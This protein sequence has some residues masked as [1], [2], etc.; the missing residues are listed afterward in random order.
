MDEGKIDG[1]EDWG[2]YSSYPTPEHPPIYVPDDLTA[3][4]LM[5]YQLKAHLAFY[6]RPKMAVHHF[7][8]VRTLKLE[9]ARMG[10]AAVFEAGRKMLLG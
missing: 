9:D 4:D 6:L 1:P 7:L 2:R 8:R 5:D 10:V 3:R